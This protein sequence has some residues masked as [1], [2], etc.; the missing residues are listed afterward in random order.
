MDE[1]QFPAFDLSVLVY[2]QHQ[3]L[4]PVHRRVR[5][6]VEPRIQVRP[7]PRIQERLEPRIQVRLEP[8]I[9]ARTAG[10]DKT[11]SEKT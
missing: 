7:E 4:W 8:R 1:D 2:L 11:T 9:Q 5:V 3:L 10:M 6:R